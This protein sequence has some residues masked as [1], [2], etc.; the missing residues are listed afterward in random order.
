M[1]ARAII[2]ATTYLIG[3]VDGLAWVSGVRFRVG[4]GDTNRAFFG[5]ETDQKDRSLPLINPVL[6]FISP[7]KKRGS[8]HTTQQTSLSLVGRSAAATTT[9]KDASTMAYPT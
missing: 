2:D 3:R 1:V 8:T 5:L 9:R 6:A 4:A 7:S